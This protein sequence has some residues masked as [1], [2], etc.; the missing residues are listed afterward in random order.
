MLSS[1]Y[2]E[3]CGV[4]KYLVKYKLHWTFPG[5]N[6]FYKQKE[7]YMW[8]KEPI[9]SWINREINRKIQTLKNFYVL[10]LL[11]WAF[12][13]M[14]SPLGPGN[15]LPPWHLGHSCGYP[16]VPPPPLLHISVQFSN[17]LYFFS[18]SSHT[19]SCPSF[20]LSPLLSLPGSS[21]PLPLVIIL[22]PF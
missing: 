18:V 21:L 20:F 22:S 19:W 3:L 7:M 6:E 1:K 4:C 9:L 2:E 15:R 17:P 13:V 10:P 5:A 11:W 16:H 8:T 14:S 12:W